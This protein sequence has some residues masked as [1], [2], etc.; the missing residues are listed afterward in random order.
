M[1]TMQAPS[2][3]N[4][5]VEL[6]PN[7]FT[8]RADFLALLAK[9]LHETGTT[10]ARLEN[11]LDTVGRK[12]NVETSV[13]SSPTIIILSM[14]DDAR[15][16]GG[17]HEQRRAPRKDVRVLRL[18]PSDVDL[19]TLC[20]IDDIAERV[21]AGELDAES[22]A[23]ALI[24]A[25]APVRPLRMWLETLTGFTL[26]SAGVASL[27]HSAW[28]EILIAAFVGAFLGLVHLLLGAKRRFAGG[29]DALCA[30]AAA[31]IVTAAAHFIAPI[32]YSR[33]L[34]A[35]VIVLV[36][37]LSIT[38]AAAEIATHHLVSG[39]ARMSGAFATLLKLAFGALVGAELA[40]GLG[41]TPILG[42]LEPTADWVGWCGLF[43]S[44]VSFALLFKVLWKDYP[45]AIFASILGFACVRYGTNLYGKEFG[46]FFAGLTVA[47]TANLY[48]RIRKRPGALIRLPGIILL[49][50]GSVGFKS[51]FLVVQKDV[52]LGMDSAVGLLLLVL[53]LVAGLL[54]ASTLVSPRYS[55]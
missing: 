38:S 43:V 20:A 40:K 54:L 2:Q 7:A 13:F 6:D 45:L 44:A 1:L 35:S 28:A 24:L 18:N 53:S 12:L 26:A 30:I 16:T 41:M 4:F 47:V 15:R 29:L 31:F 48:A 21:A 32:D 34:L 37:G 22:G 42:V 39:T 46:V 27:L 50:P 51:L 3:P 17:G 33:T 5:D 8:A 9:R 19:R 25:S 36:P 23:R 55:L 11:A 10:A 49:V 52:F 14:N